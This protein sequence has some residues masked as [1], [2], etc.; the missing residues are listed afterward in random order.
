VAPL[1]YRDVVRLLAEDLV[2]VLLGDNGRTA[3]S[4]QRLDLALAGAALADLILL[5]RVGLSGTSLPVSAGP[6]PPLITNEFRHSDGMVSRSRN[7]KAE[8]RWR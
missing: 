1:V 3:I 6:L 7:G 4:R 2:L 8:I 5:R